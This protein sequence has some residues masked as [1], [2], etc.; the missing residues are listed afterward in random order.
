MAWRLRVQEVAGAAAALP[1]AAAAVART[2]AVPVVACRCVATRATASTRPPTARTSKRSGTPTATLRK[3]KAHRLEA[4]EATLPSG[5]REKCASQAT[6]RPLTTAC[7][8]VQEKRT[9]Q[10]L[11][12]I[13]CLLRSRRELPVSLLGVWPGEQSFSLRTAQ[14][15][16][17]FYRQKPAA[18]NCGNS[19]QRLG[20]GAEKN[21]RFKCRRCGS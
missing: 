13:P 2:V 12:S 18:R 3:A 5:P 17:G 9:A 4:V 6:V 8:S 1:K 16:C 7:H 20:N 11:H 21:K 10:F 14:E 15:H 19:T